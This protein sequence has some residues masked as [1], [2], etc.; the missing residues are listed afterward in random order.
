M[1]QVL[2]ADFL[3]CQSQDEVLDFLSSAP[4]HAVDA[5]E[6]L[7]AVQVQL[8]LNKSLNV[9]G[10]QA[11][12]QDEVEQEAA[13]TM[14]FKVLGRLSQ[15]SKSQQEVFETLY[16]EFSNMGAGVDQ[17]SLEYYNITKDQFVGMLGRIMEMEQDALEETRSDFESLFEAF[18]L[19]KNGTLDRRGRNN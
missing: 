7:A 10:R 14:K 13:V 1:W 18:D 9:M 4:R 16:D 6:L 8:T 5:D 2:E 3:T 12:I 17:N 11:E 19:D 15:G